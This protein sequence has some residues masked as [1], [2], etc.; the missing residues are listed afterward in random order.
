MTKTSKAL[1][2]DEAHA[3][4]INA[5]INQVLAG[6]TPTKREAK[7]SMSGKTLVN[8]RRIKREEQEREKENI[9]ECTRNH[10]GNIQSVRDNESIV[11]DVKDIEE[12]GIAYELFHAVNGSGCGA[13][14]M[15]DTDAMEVVGIWKFDTIAKADD[16]FADAI[17]GPF[18][19]Q[20]ATMLV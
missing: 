13:V 14:R 15:I 11:Y 1:L 12:D 8:W 17:N 9:M 3:Y 4:R 6:F 7:T 16:F 20:V 10:I 19:G 2:K 18:A 5:Y